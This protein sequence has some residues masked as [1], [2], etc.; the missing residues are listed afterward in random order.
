MVDKEVAMKR[1][2]LAWFC[3]MSKAW[4]L[5]NADPNV[6][7]DPNFIGP[8]SLIWGDA[9]VLCSIDSVTQRTLTATVLASEREITANRDYQLTIFVQNPTLSIA[10]YESNPLNVWKLDTFDSP[11]SSGVLPTFR[12]S[13]TLPGYPIYNKARQW[14]DP[15]TGVSYR[16][17][18]SQIP[19]LFI[20]LQLPTKL[21]LGD[22]I[23][24]QAPEGFQFND[25]LRLGASYF[26]V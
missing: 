9:D 10:P 8:P 15:I 16:N 6:P 14:V 1:W 22:V 19:G 12:D 11:S 21:I 17:G 13:I 18:L 2:S 7:P 25:V 5:G 4:R 26:G 23:S 24:I 3:D 20:Q